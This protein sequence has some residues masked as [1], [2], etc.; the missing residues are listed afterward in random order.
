M[1]L[2]FLHRTV[3]LHRLTGTCAGIVSAPRMF[4]LNQSGLASVLNGGIWWNRRCHGVWDFSF[5]VP[6]Q[7]QR[8][9]R[10]G[11]QERLQ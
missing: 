6:P 1:C 5:L 10:K 3:V 8:F 2:G 11:W 7:M 4:Q 9:P